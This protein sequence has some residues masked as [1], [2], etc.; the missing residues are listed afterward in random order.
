M[1]LSPGGGMYRDKT[2]SVVIPCYNEEDGVK[3]V[4]ESLPPV[5]D[6]V[7]VVDNNCTDRTAE[8]ARSLGAKVVEEKTPGY[9]AAY[10][11]GLA[12]ATQDIVVTMD[13]DGTYPRDEIP[14]LV[15]YMLDNGLDFVS[16]AR[17]PLSDR[18]AMG[19]TNQ[20]GNFILTLGTQILF[21]KA[22][23]DSQS[24]MWVFKREC[25]EHL[26]LT[27]DGMPFSE[28]IKIEAIR[29]K[30]VKFAERHIS[31]APRIGEIKLNKWRDGFTNLLFLLK[32]RFRS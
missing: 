11:T 2:I 31:Y 17:F 10:K 30:H 3:F 32:L 19:F 12:A 9:G 14:D 27:S 22:V 8:V 21:F 26:R 13:G 18:N 16:A 6:E 4:I 5:I 7:V 15:D 20:L 1:V 29:S 25:L 23:K 24:G 28:E